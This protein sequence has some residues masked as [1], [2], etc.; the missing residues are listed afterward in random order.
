M[1]ASIGVGVTPS[2]AVRALISFVKAHAESVNSGQVTRQ[3]V[4]VTTAAE[5]GRQRQ[6]VDF[7]VAHGYVVPAT[8][9][10]RV[11]TV[12]HRS[13]TTETLGACFWLPS[14]EYR[15]CGHRHVSERPG[16]PGLGAG[17]RHPAVGQRDLVGRYSE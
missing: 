11:V 16:A 1:Q 3:L 14:T 12:L 4:A 5:L 8:P 2:R 15:G 6:V 10:V 13:A 9:M 7:A 17:G